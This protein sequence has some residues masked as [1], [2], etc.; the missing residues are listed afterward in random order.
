MPYSVKLEATIKGLTS[1]VKL[2]SISVIQAMSTDT[3]ALFKR[4]KNA[5]S[6]F[7]YN[8]TMIE[9]NVTAKHDNN[10]VYQLP[11]PIGK[12]YKIDQGYNGNST[13]QG[14]NALD[15]HMDE[16][17]EISAIRDGLVVEA[18]ESNKKGCPEEYCSQYN[19]YIL[20]LHDDGTFADYSHLLKNG[21]LVK[22]GEKVKAGQIIGLSGKTGIA[23]GPHLHLEVYIMGWE[24]QQSIPV[25]YQ[26][27]GKATLPVEGMSYL[28]D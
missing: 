22:V 11:Y 16:G 18:I 13:H 26:V 2:P 12:A 19:N 4:E 20:V 23:S 6:S 25:K 14:K 3:I 8:T 1:N 21:A 7:K 10:H 9:G 27:N 15:F 28:K 17:T 24:G 5:A